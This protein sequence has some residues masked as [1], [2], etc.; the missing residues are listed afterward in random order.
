MRLLSSSLAALAVF[1]AV[2]QVQAAPFTFTSTGQT[3]STSYSST[4]DG[5]TLSA[6]INYTLTGWSGNSATF[7]ISVANNSTGPGLNRLVSFGVGVITPTLLSVSVPNPVWDGSVNG[8]ITNTDVDFCAYGGS[9]C[10]GGGGPSNS[11]AE[12][13]TLNLL[14]T[15]TFAAGTDVTTAGIRF[16]E[17]FRVRF[18]SIGTSDGSLAFNGTCTNCGNTVPEPGSLALAGLALLAAAAARRRRG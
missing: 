17:P 18:Q 3:L 6:T 4:L 9:N 14:S 8:Q 11:V 5:A 15:W 13:D 10:N 12:G 2:G 1:C 7:A 16:D